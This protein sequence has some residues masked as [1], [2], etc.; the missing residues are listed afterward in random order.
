MVAAPGVIIRPATAADAPGMS[1]VLRDIVAWN[2]RARE[3]GP[4]HVLATYV[5]HPSGLLCSVACE[6]DG[7]VLG[8][9]SMLSAAADNAYGTPEGWGIIG[10]HIAPGAHGRGIGR[11]L[12][13]A[14]LD[15]AQQ[16]SLT[17]IE[18][19]IAA[20]NNGA[21]AFYESL[22]FRTRV[23]DA[24]YLRKVFVVAPR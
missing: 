9:Q 2:G 21:Q 16:A 5:R 7:A 1:R 13:A 8:F 10:T 3:T 18:A 11:A 20:D 22:G 15:A 12:F 19:L 6:A 24:D 23:A 17:R 4:E 14:S